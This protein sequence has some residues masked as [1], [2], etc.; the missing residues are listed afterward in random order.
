MRIILNGQQAF[1]K[2]VLEALLERGD[3]RSQRPF[4]TGSRFS[5][6]ARNPS[7]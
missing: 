4:H 6:N 2:A 1:G 3:A 5:A 7:I